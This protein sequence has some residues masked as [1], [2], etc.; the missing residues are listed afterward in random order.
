MCVCVY[1]CVCVCV[2]VYVYV[3]LCV[4]VC[5]CVCV[6]VYV[7]M[8]V[9]VCVSRKIPWHELLTDLYS[10]PTTVGVIKSRRMRWAR[11]VARMG[12]GDVCEGFGWKT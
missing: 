12:W 10:L 11:Y 1:V 9:C 2:C 5:V 3:C 8:C 7:C 4:C 6:Y